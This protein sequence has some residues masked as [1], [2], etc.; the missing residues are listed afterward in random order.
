MATLPFQIAFSVI[1]VMLVV[2]RVHHR[3][4]SS[5]AAVRVSPWQEVGI[6]EVAIWVPSTVDVSKAIHPE[7]HK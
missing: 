4:T 2:V 1:A 6:D 3:I 7:E 5:T